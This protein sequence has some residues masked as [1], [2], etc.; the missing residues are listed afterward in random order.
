MKSR[1]R[2]AVG[3]SAAALAMTGLAAPASATTEAEPTVR[4]LLEQ[5]EN[6]NTD[7]C[8]FHPSGAPETR[9]GSYELVG[10][11][12]NCS[13]GTSTRIISWQSTRGTTTNVSV[14]ISAGVTLGEVFE[15]GFETSYER[16]WSW[17]TTKSDEIRHELGPNQAVNIYAAP[18]R[19]Q[20]TGTYELHFGDPYY[21]HYYWYVH[22]V[23]VDGPQENPAW[24]TRVESK[25]ANC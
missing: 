18:M 15:A 11:A 4:Q 14:T 17:S 19:Q 20:V 12:T 9:R 24:Q 1:N 16:Q 2:L 7:L 10:G 23:T 22:D 25:T 8:E 3:L 6:G 13:E 21:G 5:C